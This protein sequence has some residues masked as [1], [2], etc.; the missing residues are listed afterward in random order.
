MRLYQL[1]LFAMSENWLINEG[2][3]VPLEKTS[4]S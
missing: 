3:T 1:N 4:Q 2:I